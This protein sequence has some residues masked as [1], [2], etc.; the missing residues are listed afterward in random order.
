MARWLQDARSEIEAAW[1]TGLVPIV[2]GGTGLY[3]K[4]L[5]QGLA[6]VPPIAAECREKWRNFTGDLHAELVRRD[7]SAAKQLA[8]ADRQRILRALEVIEGTG[9]PLAHWQEV[10][11]SDA[12]LAGADVERLFLSCRAKR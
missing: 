8:P 5:L 4:A 12:V 2:T 10:A 3:F 6:E 9:R 1:R 7:P 11:Q